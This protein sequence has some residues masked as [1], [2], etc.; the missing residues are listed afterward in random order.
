MSSSYSTPTAPVLTDSIDDDSPEAWAWV[1]S[2]EAATIDDAIRLAEEEMPLPSDEEYRCSGRK[3]WFCITRSPD[4]EEIERWEPC[5]KDDPGAT[6]F[7][8]LEV[9]YLED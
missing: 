7:W 4:G 2:T 6:S 8:D 1:D 5:S 3:S 9:V